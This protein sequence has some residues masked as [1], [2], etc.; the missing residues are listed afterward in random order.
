ML[1]STPARRLPLLCLPVACLVATAGCSSAVAST[2]PKGDA[3]HADAVAHDASDD[4]S[5]GGAAEPTLITEPDDGMTPVFAFLR[6]AKTS[7]D[8]TMY[9][10]EDSTVTGILTTAAKSGVTVRVILDQNLEK[11]RNTTA[12][13]AL[14]AGGV[15][16]H[17][18]NS[19]YSATHQ[20]TI[21]VD[22]TTSAIM[23]LN[24]TPQYYSTSREFVVL[25]TDAA[26]V[27]AI[28]ATFNADFTNTSVNPPTGDD[29]VWSP[30]NAQSALDGIIGGAK[31]SL[32]VE[33]EEMNEDAIV[34]A[35]ASAASRGV[36]V[37]VV[38]TA[39]S[40]WDAN[41]TTLT[42]AG[43]KVV[44]YARNAPLYIHAKVIVADYSASAGS[45]FIGSENFS[46]ASLQY[47]RELGLITSDR[48]ILDSV[49][50][51]LARDFSGGTAYP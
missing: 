51:T 36:N 14:T 9:E 13:N 10:L 18:A 27:A 31:A 38:M 46:T 37:E 28:E 19:T 24:F 6:T 15:A 25:T 50:A 40:S 49:H 20:K 22:G 12:F 39:S 17:W 11:S 3:G 4:S 32:L 48:G 47:N 26:D 42:A 23:S 5:D 1:S 16:A 8:L 41:F 30:T 44:T 2:P 43:V 33:N 34:S 45:V 21:T 7:I 29:L 35:L